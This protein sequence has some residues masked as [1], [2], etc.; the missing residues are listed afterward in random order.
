MT[1]TDIT[2]ACCANPSTFDVIR[3][4][5]T[6]ADGSVKVY[7]Y[8]RKIC[9]KCTYKRARVKTYQRKNKAKKP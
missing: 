9:G 4:K 8:K 5:V 7:T 2:P 3:K 1:T 6:M